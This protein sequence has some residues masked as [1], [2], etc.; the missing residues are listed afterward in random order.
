MRI[1]LLLYILS[2]MASIFSADYSSD[3]IQMFVEKCL[4]AKDAI[5]NGKSIDDDN[6][7]PLF[8]EGDLGYPPFKLISIALN[9]QDKNTETQ[10]SELIKL[11]K[12]KSVSMFALHDLLMM[13]FDRRDVYE[14]GMGL[15]FPLS[16]YGSD[17]KS[18]R[19]NSSH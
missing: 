19:L 4:I 2:S 13:D 9:R 8:E 11:I 14:R 5:Q 12:H 7:I 17:R 1:F 18:T 10:I 6:E 16:K 3:D 15:I